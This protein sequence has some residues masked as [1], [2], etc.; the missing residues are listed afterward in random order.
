MRCYQAP[1]GDLF[2]ECRV[3]TRIVDHPTLVLHVGPRSDLNSVGLPQSLPETAL[4]KLDLH[5]AIQS[6][7]GRCVDSEYQP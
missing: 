7:Y 3:G 2:A 5:T 1:S 4:C 6:A